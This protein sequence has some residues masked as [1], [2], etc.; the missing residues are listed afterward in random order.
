M[1]APAWPRPAGS[2]PTPS[3]SGQAS[4]AES[5]ASSRPGA[6]GRGRLV[7]EGQREHALERAG[8]AAAPPRSPPFG[9]GLLRGVPPPRR[10]RSG[11][12]GR[13]GRDP[14]ARRADPRGPERDGQG[15][16]RA[17]PGRRDVRQDPGRPA[18]TTWRCSSGSPRSG[19][20][21][22]I[23]TTGTDQ[24]RPTRRT[25]RRSRSASGWRPRIP[26]EPRFRMALS[27]S[28]NGLAITQQADAEV[29][30]AYRRSLELRLK[31]ADEI[32]EDPDLL[33][34]L[35]ESFL[36]LGILLWNDG[37]REEAV[38]LTTHAIDY[39]RAGVARRPHD[40]EFAS[41]LAA[42]LQQCRRFLLAARAPRRG[43]GALGRGHRLRAQALGGQSRGPCL[44]RRAG[45]C[46][47]CAWPST[48]RS[49]GG[50]TRP[51]RRA[52][53]R[54]EILE[55]KPDP[56]AG[57]LAT[58][59]FYRGHVAGLL[60][61]DAACARIP[62]LAGGGPPRGGPGGRGPEGG[63]R[64][65]LPAGR[66]HP[67]GCSLQVADGPRRREVAPGRDGT[68]AGRARAYEG[69]GTGGHGACTIAAGP[70]GPARGGSHP[71]RADH[72]IGHRGRRAPD[73]LRAAWKRC[74]TGS[75][76]GGSHVRI[77]PAWSRSR[78]RSGCN[79][80]SSSGRTASWPR[81]GASGM[82]YSRRSAELPADD[83]G[84]QAI[85]A[86]S[87]R[88]AA[89]QP[90]CLSRAACGSGPPDTTGPTGPVAPEESFFRCYGIEP[91]GPGERRRRSLS[92][93]SRPEAVSRVGEGDELLVLHALRTATLGRESPVAP[94]GSWRWPG[95]LVARGPATSG[96]RGI[97]SNWARPV[98][99]GRH[100]EALAAIG[101]ECN[102]L[103]GK[104]VVARVRARAGRAE[105]AGRWLQALGRDIEAEIGRT[106]P[107]SVRSGCR[108]CSRP[109]CS[110]PTSCAGKPMPR[111][112]RRLPSCGAS[113]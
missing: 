77:R 110:G 27:R 42:R 16:R 64:P 17:A 65:G 60:A 37:H 1:S 105:Q 39:G 41:D 55:T 13:P 67:R 33:H 84:R 7:H 80:A 87:H 68:S 14:G 63:R 89:D 104:A 38:E 75:R 71:G 44:P 23:S 74:W 47:R 79:S 28:L 99:A 59:A 69:A 81:P 101:E 58:A 82:T 95:G 29:R 113:G 30:D 103:N 97:G 46:D 93:R 86:R 76:R 100:G 88:D 92:E 9:A 52:G 19:T 5:Q 26:A 78:N 20:G 36:N 21:S 72:R 109:M 53:R 32:P 61:G 3:G 112:A 107:H 102:T 62:V 25:A 56:D 90:S 54:P 108:T 66:P 4:L 49:S 11:P 57:A 83:R 35:G 12:P 96:V 106:L 98:R 18:R 73:R 111:S 31:L 51:C 34:G 45:R 40:L 94:R 15:S 10:R 43:P 70:A 22:A 2:T 8:P 48:S 6:E 91:A 50:P 85:L 24:R